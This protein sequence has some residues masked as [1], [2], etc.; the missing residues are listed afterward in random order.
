[1]KRL[2]IKLISSSKI[3]S[4][5][6]NFTT[7]FANYSSSIS[8][9][10]IQKPCTYQNLK[11][12]SNSNSL[13]YKPYK[14]HQFH[15]NLSHNYC[16]HV[17]I[18]PDLD[19]NQSKIEKKSQIDEVFDEVASAEEMIEA[20]KEM[21]GN[22]D[23]GDIGLACFRIAFQLDREG[24]DFE[25]LISFANRALV[26]FD[27]AGE[28]EYSSYVAVSLQLLGCTNYSLRKFDD[29]LGFLNRANEIL[30]KLDNDGKY[31]AYDIKSILHDVQMELA[32]VHVA[33]GMIEAGLDNLRKALGYK[34]FLMGKDSR[35][36]GS[37]NRE[38]AEACAGN[39][40]FEGA[41]PYGLKALEIHER[42]NGK[43]SAEVANDR[44][45]LGVIYNGMGEYEKALEENRMAQK[46]FKDT[47]YYERL[48][49]VVIEA[50]DIY[51]A[52]GRYEAAMIML[53]EH[54]KE[55]GE[56]TDLLI[57]IAKVLVYQEKFADAKTCLEKACIRLGKLEKS[58]PL[59]VSEAYMD[60]A[61]EYQAMDEFEIA[62]SLL[63]RAHDL[64][65]KF[66]DENHIEG[67]V[68]GR[69]GWILLLTGKVTEA[70][71]YLESAAETLKES[72]GSKHY[73]V[74][75]VYNNL[76]AAYLEMERLESATQMFAAAKDIMD[77]SSLG[78]H[79]NDSI[80]ACQNL[81]KAYAAMKSYPLA[82]E[83]Q[84]K[85]VEAWEG[86]GSSEED[87]LTEARQLL[88]Q[89][90]AI[91]GGASSKDYPTKALP[92]PYKAARRGLM[93][94]QPSSPEQSG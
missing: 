58:T 20:F 87:E 7:Q 32:N 36:F 28:N 13:F 61:R 41:L 47:R 67:I 76:G 40:N 31:D 5:S 26:S 18:T 19:S 82:I 12:C 2:S 69:L 42:T 39:E 74:G 88:E 75:Y 55:F 6:G 30:V 72:Y 22:L 51:I 66:P 85:A 78:P 64:L 49:S 15:N 3:T 71:P 24:E 50:A 1:M 53:K 57:T 70:I 59:E 94:P 29:A 52:L 92:L 34:E 23:E 63:K 33:M 27:K 8:Q 45:V 89:L 73:V 65:V 17:G 44:Q 77:A 38:F 4:I 60:I 11:P 25:K 37:A 84:Q 48:R 43:Y 68:S 86:H 46:I 80:Q 21:E 35:E 90:K 56:K 16:T 54:E 93:A 14:T 83:F 9:S 81:S 79:H 10:P 62:I 91:A